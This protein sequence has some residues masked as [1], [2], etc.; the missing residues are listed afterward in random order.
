MKPHL[1]LVRGNTSGKPVVFQHGLC[2]NSG[3]TTEA[4]PNDPRFQMHTLECRGHGASEHGPLN[5]FSINTFAGDIAEMVEEHNLAP[6]IIGGIS[7]GAAISLNLAVHRPHLVKALVLARPAWLTE[8]NPDNMKPNAEIGE[9]LAT[10]SAED[11]KALFLQSETA[12]QL[13]KSAPDNLA[14][15]TSFFA[16]EPLEVTAALLSSIS[17]DGPGVTEQQVRALKIPT[18]IVATEQDAIHP[19]SHAQTLHE[20]IAHSCLAVITPKGVDKSRY[21]HEFQST[22]LKFFEENA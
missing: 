21:I 22:L 9:L 4:F 1:K 15:L 14:S 12:R 7:M 5:A 18:L 20:M 11:A 2:G 8:S 6:L 10:H 16:R 17:R 3:Q 13:S 19:L